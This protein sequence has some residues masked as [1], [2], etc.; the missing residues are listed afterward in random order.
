MKAFR[1]YK[2]G[3]A[4]SLF[5]SSLQFRKNAD[6]L[7]GRGVCLLF[8]GDAGKGIQTLDQAR[9][10]RH[11]KGTPFEN[12]YEGLFYFFQNDTS[13]AVPLLEAASEHTDYVWAVTK[14]FAVIQLDRNRPDEASKLM[15]PYLQAKITEPD[16]AYIVARLE[17]AEGKN[18][19]ART[20]VDNF[21]STSMAPYWKQRF[22]QLRIT[23]KNG[24]T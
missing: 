9:S 17:L 10:M 21:F 6:A 2:L 12:F 7:G 4:L 20:I 11:G 23:L 14:L 3:P 13:N 22:E 1:D 18:A 5:D 15:Q 16:Q 19:E 24:K 8:D